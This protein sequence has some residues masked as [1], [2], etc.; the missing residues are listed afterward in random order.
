M[1]KLELIKALQQ[2]SVDMIE[3]GTAIDYY[4]GLNPLAAHGGEMV[5]AGM[6]AKEWADEMEAK[7]DSRI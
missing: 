1:T 5:R 6:M 2:L 3:V 7:H 4:Y